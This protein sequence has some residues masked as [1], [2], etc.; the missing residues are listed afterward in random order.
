[1]KEK[2]IGPIIE[3]IEIKKNDVIT[4]S[5]TDWTNPKNL[6]DVNDEYKWTPFH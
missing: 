3:I 5:D 6:M 1:M 4:T 2:Y